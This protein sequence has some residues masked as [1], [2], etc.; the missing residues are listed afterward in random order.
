MEF[1]AW[2]QEIIDEDL[3]NYTCFLPERKWRDIHDDNSEVKRVFANILCGDKEYVCALGRPV[4][5]GIETGGNPIFLPPWLVQAMG[6]EGVGDSVTVN[7][8]SEEHA[9]EATKIVLRPHE[10]AFYHGDAR[11]ELEPVLTQYG[12]L[13]QGTTIPVPIEALGGYVVLFD[14][15]AT[16]PA[17]L[18]LMQGDE[19]AIEFEQALDWVE[20]VVPAA[21]A[22]PPS[23]LQPVNV[24]LETFDDDEALLP[25]TSTPEPSD[26]GYRLGG[27]THPPL[28][29]GRPWNPWRLRV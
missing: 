2:S 21:A 7:W 9:P 17:E 22:A 28:P 16:E 1:N 14:V 27:V 26:M 24:P 15:I 20:P 3:D 10:A 19:V 25:A 18:V 13:K 5:S 4:R 6:L 12:M 8:I 23:A 29:D 11:D